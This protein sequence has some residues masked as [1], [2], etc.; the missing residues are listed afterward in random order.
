MK[1]LL[2][3]LIITCFIVVVPCTAKTPKKAKHRSN[4]AEYKHLLKTLER[5]CNQQDTIAN[6]LRKRHDYYVGSIE[7]TD[8]IFEDALRQRE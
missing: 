2:L 5:I 3:V 8:R 6:V 4:R 1:K 7:A